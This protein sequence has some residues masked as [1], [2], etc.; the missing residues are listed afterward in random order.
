[1]IGDEDGAEDGV[2]DGKFHWTLRVAGSGAGKYGVCGICGD[3]AIGED[4]CKLAAMPVRQGY[5]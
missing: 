2:S 5:S 3:A 4:F 1:V